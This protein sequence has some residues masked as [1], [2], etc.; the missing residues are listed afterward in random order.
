MTVYWPFRLEPSANMMNHWLLARV[1]AVALARHADDAALVGHV[2]ELGLEV[3]ILRAA[4][5][6]AVLAVAGLRHE[7]GDDAVERHAV[8]EALARELLQPRRMPRRDVVAQLDDDAA[9]RG[10][11]HQRVLRVGAGR[12]RDRLGEARARQAAV[13][14]RRQADGSCELPVLSRRLRCE[15]RFQPCH[16]GGRHEGAD[17]AA[18]LGDLAHQSGGDRAHRGA[19]GQED[20]LDRRRHR[21]V[22]PGHLHFVVEIGG[23][24][25][26]ADQQGRALALAR[27]RPR[28]HRRPCRPVRRRP[29][30]RSA[31]RSRSAWRAAPRTE[32]SASC[33]D[34][35]R[36]P[37]P[38]GRQAAPPA[39]PR[40]GGRW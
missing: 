31:R 20:G 6:V 37:A 7:A 21:A 5:A 2:G 9:L 32:T 23:V 28:G 4:G 30:W 34:G 27:G 1:V 38:A 29:P 13:R 10:V 8:V 24:A 19:R 39:A 16:H 17:V 3:G 40:R 33:P 35:P 26:A 14:P 15:F 11:D 18:H 25:Q 36:S 12:Q 22:H